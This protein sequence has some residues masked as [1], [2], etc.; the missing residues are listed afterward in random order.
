MRFG[1]FPADVLLKILSF[2]RVVDVLKI[3]MMNK[4]LRDI[5][6]I[7][8]V[9]L[10]FLRNADLEHAPQMSPS[11][12]ADALTDAE[13][14]DHVVRAVRGH[15]NWSSVNPRVTSTIR[16]EV[17]GRPTLLRVPSGRRHLI[18]YLQHGIHCWDLTGE[19]QGQSINVLLTM[20]QQLIEV[21]EFNFHR[22][23]AEVRCTKTVPFDNAV[24]PRVNK[25]CMRG[26]FVVVA[27]TRQ[28]IFV[29]WETGVMAFATVPASMFIFNVEIIDRSLLFMAFQVS[30]GQLL[31]N[32]D[33][34]LAAASLSD[35]FSQATMGKTAMPNID[36][37]LST[38]ITIDMS[39]TMPHSTDPIGLLKSVTLH[40]AYVPSS[41]PGSY[42]GKDELID[43][44]SVLSAMQNPQSRLSGGSTAVPGHINCHLYRHSEPGYH[45]LT[46]ASVWSGNQGG[47][48]QSKLTS[49]RGM[50]VNL[51]YDSGAV[52]ATGPDMKKGHVLLEYY[53]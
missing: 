42:S 15:Y 16:I 20:T 49:G 39:A 22:N 30:A 35:I 26:P 13:L 34:K 5:V 40:G 24:E 46:L 28:F 33:L 37:F 23:L 6:S 21:V 38:E 7:R 1:E 18:G 51:D 41:I 4:R 14:R 27:T 12:S 8:S 47:L 25:I 3:E 44:I 9:W 29:N 43:T 2:C 32:S 17:G 11:M 50:I 31:E 48:L 19:K 10:Y 53:D 36:D 52:Y 45:A